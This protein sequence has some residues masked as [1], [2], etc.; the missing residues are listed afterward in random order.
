MK[1]GLTVEIRCPQGSIAFQSHVDAAQES[2][3]PANRELAPNETWTWNIGSIP[4]ER[5]AFFAAQSMLNASV[6]INDTET[7]LE[8]QQSTDFGIA[9]ARRGEE[10][11]GTLPFT[12]DLTLITVTNMTD[13]KNRISIM[14]GEIV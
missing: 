2:I 5:I 3:R 14:F 10:T 8:G 11:F 1:V 9:F 6:T 12:G 4:P 13:K 7:L